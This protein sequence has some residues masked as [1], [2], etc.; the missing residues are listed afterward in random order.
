SGAIG[1]EA[2]ARADRELKDATA[3]Y[4][5]G[6][7]ETKEKGAAPPPAAPG[8]GG[9]GR[10]EYAAGVRKRLGE[11]MDLGKRGGSAA[12][13]SKLGR[14]FQYA[15]ARPVTLPRQKSA[16]LPIVAKD[17]EADRVSI[18]NERTQ[19]K[20]PLLGVKVKNTSGVHLNQGPITVFEA[21][22]YAG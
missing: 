12:T 10:G 5:R 6:A 2:L 13:A 4:R 1:G 15:I 20:F 9:P 8:F 16:M 19:A 3:E 21:S 18:Y 7:A 22:N 17:I 14:F 11:E